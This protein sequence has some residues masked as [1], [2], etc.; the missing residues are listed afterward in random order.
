MIVA[1]TA[2]DTLDSREEAK[3]K[4]MFAYLTKPINPKQIKEMI[5]RPLKPT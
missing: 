2:N 3:E 1:I 4:G 5:G